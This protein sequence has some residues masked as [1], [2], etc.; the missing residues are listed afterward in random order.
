MLKT[1]FDMLLTVKGSFENLAN[2]GKSD[3][4]CSLFSTVKMLY[5]VLDQEKEVFLLCS[6]YLFGQVFVLISSQNRS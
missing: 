1:V 4:T 5:V 2:I 3:A 6:N